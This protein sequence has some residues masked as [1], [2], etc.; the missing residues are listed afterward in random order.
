[1]AA[2]SLQA[3]ATTAGDAAGWD[4]QPGADLSIRY[5]WLLDEHRDELLAVWRQL[6]ECLTQRSV[7]LDA[8]QVRLWCYG[9]RSR[10]IQ[11]TQWMPVGLLP[12]RA[13]YPAAFPPGGGGDPARKRSLIAYQSQL[14]HQPQ[15][16]GLADVSSIGAAELIPTAD[17]PDERRESLDELVPG[18]LVAVLGRVSRAPTGGTPSATAAEPP[19]GLAHIARPLANSLPFLAMTGWLCLALPLIKG[20]PVV[21]LT[22]ERGRSPSAQL[23]PPRRDGSRV[24]PAWW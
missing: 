9:A 21:R 13:Q 4:A 3:A 18:A 20:T 11:G 23:R 12:G 16:D 10:R 14:I 15:P 5:R 7:T 1:M 6:A 17:R 22:A 24:G 8:E 19:A 2:Q